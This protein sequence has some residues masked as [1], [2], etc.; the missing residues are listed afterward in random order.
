MLLILSP[1]CT[2]LFYFCIYLPV[3]R[4]RKFLLHL[5]FPSAERDNN[6]EQQEGRANPRPAPTR[7]EMELIVK[8][9]Q[10]LGLTSHHFAE[11]QDLKDQLDVIKGSYYNHARRTHPDKGGRP[12]DFRFYKN[13]YDFLK[14]MPEETNVTTFLRHLLSLRFICFEEDGERAGK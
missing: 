13:C 2:L 3:T 7:D 12:E 5:L 11:C 10:W 14:K 4:M 6:Q 8:A 1:V 9:L